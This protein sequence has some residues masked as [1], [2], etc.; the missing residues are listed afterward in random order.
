MF[1]INEKSETKIAQRRNYQMRKEE[2]DDRERVDGKEDDD[3][4]R[5]GR[6][7]IR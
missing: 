5:E 2:E 6:P 7:G 1:F 3:A 4:S